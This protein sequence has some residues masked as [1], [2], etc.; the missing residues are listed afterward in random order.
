MRKSTALVYRTCPNYF[1]ILHPSFFIDEFSIWTRTAQSWQINCKLH[2]YCEE[3]KTKP[4]R[5]KKIWPKCQ[6]FGRSWLG[7]REI[8]FIYLSSYWLTSTG[9]I[10]RLARCTEAATTPTSSFSHHGHRCAWGCIFTFITQM[11][12]GVSGTRCGFAPSKW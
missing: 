6:D 3:N 5:K 9:I 7:F 10:E 1:R 8:L 2:I 4:T 11:G 12:R